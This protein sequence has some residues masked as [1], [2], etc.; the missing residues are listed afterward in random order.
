MPLPTRGAKDFFIACVEGLKGFRGDRRGVPAN[1]GAIVHRARGAGLAELRELETAQGG[2]RRLAIDLPG[3]HGRD[4]EMR[5]D[6]FARKW[7]PS[8]PMVSQ[9]WRRN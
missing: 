4:A 1:G 5:R 2:R 6:E 3:R 9:I 8:Y 7:D